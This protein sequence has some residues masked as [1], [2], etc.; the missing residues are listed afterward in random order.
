MC[1][2]KYVPEVGTF[3]PRS[4]KSSKVQYQQFDVFLDRKV[5]GQKHQAMRHWDR[6]WILFILFSVPVSHGLILLTSDVSTQKD[7]K[8]LIL[9]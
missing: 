6:K 4:K 9:N 1:H 2:N 3:N 5:N 7:I 8:L